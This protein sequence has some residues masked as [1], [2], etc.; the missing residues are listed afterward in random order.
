MKKYFANFLVII[1]LSLCNSCGESKQKPFSFIQ[2]ADTQLGFGGYQHDLNSFEQAVKQINELNPDFVVICGDLVDA[3][4]DSSYADFNRIK[5]KF[6][7]PCYCIPGNH[8]IGNSPDERSL[9]YYRK[10]MGKD[11]YSFRHKG[12]LFVFTN[13]QLWK[14]NVENESFAHDKWFSKIIKSGNKNHPVFVLGHYPLYLSE[15]EEKSEYFNIEPVKRKEILDLFTESNV[16]AYLSGHTHKMIVNN[17]KGIQLVSSETTSRNF[18]ERPFG[19]R[20]WTVSNDSVS[21]QFILLKQ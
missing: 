5:E 18:D 14:L 3:P 20:L 15:P 12:F 2:L 21:H 8:D 9:L 16:V 13:T 19:M 6:N 1:L 7:M 10:V 11:Y 4:N 17:F